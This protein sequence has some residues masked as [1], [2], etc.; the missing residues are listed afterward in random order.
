L[1]DEL[2]EAFPSL[3]DFT[4]TSPPS[5][6]YNCVAWAVGTNDDWWWPNGL[7]Y[8]PPDAPL[9]VTLSA[10]IAAF[11][12]LGYET[13]ADDTPADGFQ[14]VALYA[15][16]DGQV[17]HMA[18]QLPSGRWTSKLGKAEDVEHGSPAELEGAVYGAVVW[19]MRRAV[20]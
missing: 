19:Y 14:K 11:T 9:E 18:R 10:F 17:T 12:T 8:W 2:R 1:T 15:L 4:V 6:R 16:P 20:G 7:N 3:T 5:R 13:C